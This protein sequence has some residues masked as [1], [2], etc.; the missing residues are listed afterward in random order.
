[1]NALVDLPN[2]REALLLGHMIDAY[3]AQF[4]RRDALARFKEV[5]L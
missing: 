2:E 1:M 5:Y 4:L 3:F